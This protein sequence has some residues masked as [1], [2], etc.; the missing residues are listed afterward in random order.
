[1]AINKKIR[2]RRIY[3]NIADFK[4]NLRVQWYIIYEVTTTLSVCVV[5]NLK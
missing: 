4:W 1:M 3:Q 2:F 5:V